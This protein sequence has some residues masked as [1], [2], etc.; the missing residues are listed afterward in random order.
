[1]KYVICAYRDYGIKL[2]HALKKQFDFTLIRSKN[3]LT[4][5]KIKKILF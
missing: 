2:Y 3:E 5:N 4:Y 1:M